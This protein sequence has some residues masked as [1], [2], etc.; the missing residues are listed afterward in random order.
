MSK[1]IRLRTIELQLA[2]FHEGSL[3]PQA[4]VV[5]LLQREGP[6]SLAEANRLEAGLLQ[7]VTHVAALQ[8][9]LEAGGLVPVLERSIRP[10]AT[11][12]LEQAVGS[13]RPV[14]VPP[15]PCT[16]VQVPRAVLL[17]AILVEVGAGVLNYL[18]TLQIS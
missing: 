17:K 6:L 7:V 3:P 5:S 18:A 4:Q 15:P 14:L 12:L 8:C 16:G 11:Q 1:I 13:C 9:F 10:D 2:G